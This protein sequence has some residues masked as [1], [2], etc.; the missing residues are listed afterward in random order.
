M[1]LHKFKLGIWKRWL[2]KKKKR[3]KLIKWES[4]SWR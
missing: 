1:F 2:L 4:P 3:Y